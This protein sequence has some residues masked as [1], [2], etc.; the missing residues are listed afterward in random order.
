MSSLNRRAFIQSSLI[1]GLLPLARTLSAA[2][3]AASG[4]DF[5]RP[6]AFS[7]DGLVE[8]ARALSTKPYV[9]PY[10][11]APDVVAKIDYDE[12]GKIRFKP[13]RA[14]FARGPGPYPVMFFHLG[15]W[16]KSSVKM[17]A[18]EKGQAREIFYSPDDFDMPADS[19]ARK[20]PRDSGFA[21]FRFHEARRRSDWKT[22]DWLAFLGAS[23]FRAI[24]DLG[25]YGISARGIALNTSAAGTSEEFPEFTEFYIEPAAS[26]GQPAFV[27]ALLSGPSVTGA[28]RFTCHRNKN[29]VMEV[30][31]NL[32]VRNSIAQL[33]LAPLT[34][35]FWFAEYDA[36]FRVDWRPEI[37]DSDGLALWT[38]AGERIW[39]PLHAPLRTVTSSFVDK[40]PRG[41]GLLQRDRTFDHYLDGVRY[42]RRPS[43]WVEPLGDWG[44]GAVKLVEI[45]T[46]D[47]IHDNI[48]AFW[49]SSQPAKAG[50][51]F[52]LSYRLH[53]QA[54]EPFP[55]DNVAHVYSTRI[56]KGGKP[57]TVRPKGVTKFVVDF[58]GKPLEAL[59]RDTKPIA[60]ITASR[61]EISYVFVEPVPDTKRWRTQ[62]DLALNGTEPAEIRMFLRNGDKTLSETWLCQYDPRP[63]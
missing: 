57:G 47:E 49:E 28:Y 39:R 58:A 61:G 22:Q 30:D 17:H 20:L 27:Y 3:A 11:P 46:D 40:T 29:V 36:G 4:L 2:E 24:G 52:K 38:G 21:G 34:S 10:R 33:G 13:D 56:G 32:F 51:S 5:G 41:F 14:L 55:A 45:P 12:H 26:E 50:S 6:E 60:N 42:E 23:Y 16:F 37:H 44:G 18:L 35:M 53:W 54:D 63:A 9:P 31:A 62:F 1:A 15:Q 7:F 48:V 19:V 8:R 59:P 25:Q 43:L